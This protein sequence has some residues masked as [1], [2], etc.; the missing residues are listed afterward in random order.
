MQAGESRPDANVEIPEHSEGEPVTC[1]WSLKKHRCFYQCT[2]CPFPQEQSQMLGWGW[3]TTLTQG[4]QLSPN[5]G[6]W[7]KKGFIHL[8]N[9]YLLNTYYVPNAVQGREIE[10]WAKQAN[11]LSR[12]LYSMGCRGTINNQIT[13]QVVYKDSGE[14]IKQGEGEEGWN[15]CSQL[16]K[17]KIFSLS[18]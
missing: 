8:L 18:F 13:C 5:H 16:S 1:G 2:C 12:S 3:G 17:F 4:Q 9:G 6:T 7:R 15:S 11:P 10:Q 14:K